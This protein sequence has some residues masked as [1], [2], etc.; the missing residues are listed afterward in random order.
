MH[1]NHILKKIKMARHLRCVR[2]IPITSILAGL[3]LGTLAL[4]AV[5]FTIAAVN[6]VSADDAQEKTDSGGHIRIFLVPQEEENAYH[7]AKSEPDPQKRAQK[8]F[9]FIQKYPK[10]AFI[11]KSDYEETKAIKEEYDAYYTV[12]Q[13]AGIEKR[14]AML[15]EFLQKFPKSAFAADATQEYLRILEDASHGKKYELLDSLAENWLKLHPDDRQTY[16]FIAEAT[17]NLRKYQR[18]GE[19]LE[20]IYRL[21]PSPNLAREIHSVY[22]KANN[23]DKE[24]EWAGKLF[25]MPEFADDYML[26]YGYVMLFSKSNDIHKAAE[27]AKL[28]V[29]S[30]EM[31]RPKDAKEP[32]QLQKVLRACHHIIGID[33]FESGNYR[34]AITAFQKALKYE[35]YPEGYYMI[36]QCMD[37]QKEIEKAIDYY[38]VAEL[39]GGEDAPKARARLEMLYKALH[40]D[41]LIGIDKVYRKAKEM[42]AEPGDKS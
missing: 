21:Q 32:E 22:Q 20:E 6:C 2:V 13:E 40:N 42:L 18:C 1:G 41:T 5:L 4:A 24:I 38:A 33:L 16:A 34:D 11:Q 19:C 37:E 25:K 15:I 12:M 3:S 10:S 35:R 39:M 8:L 23:L 9:E 29:K 27:Y 28:T 36:G 7:A 17:L 30:A 31:A 26:R 14:A